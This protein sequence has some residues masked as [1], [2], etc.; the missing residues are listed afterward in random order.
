M[1][2][3]FYLQID[4]TEPVKNDNSPK[5][6]KRF[7][8]DYYFEEMIAVSVHPD[9]NMHW[10]EVLHKRQYSQDDDAMFSSFFVFELPSQLRILFNDEIRSENTVSEYIVTGKGLEE[11]KSLMST[12]Y[13]NL[14]LRFRE[15][16]QTGN[17]SLI[18]PSL[19]GNRLALVKID[20]SET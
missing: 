1:L 11:R 5:F 16:K 3:I 8:L 14:K 20:Y 15:A 12:D 2:F 17:Q 6:E 10:V 7:E 18:V 9:G 19:R 13:Q 4:R